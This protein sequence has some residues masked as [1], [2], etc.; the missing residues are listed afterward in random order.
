M[1]DSDFP[2]QQRITGP[3]PVV[4]VLR[5]SSC[6]YLILLYTNVYRKDG[7]TGIGS[8]VSKYKRF[9]L[10]SMNKTGSVQNL[11][12]ARVNDTKLSWQLFSN[13][14]PPTHTTCFLAKKLL[15]TTHSV[16]FPLCPM[17]DEIHN[18]S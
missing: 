13:F 8:P 9:G 6:M 12:V 11:S 1:S 16:E 3:E 7:P 14:F 5:C 15:L 18:F 4:T 10:Y 17:T 2:K